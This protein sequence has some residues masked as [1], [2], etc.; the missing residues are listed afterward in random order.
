MTQPLEIIRVGVAVEKRVSKSPW[1]S[2]IWRPLWV[3]DGIPA[4]SPGTIIS[5]SDKITAFYAGEASI[6]LYRTETANYLSNLSSGSPL[7]WIILRYTEGGSAVELRGVTA[8][9]AEG[10]ALTGSGND[11]V[12]SVPMPKGIEV[13]INAFIA[14]HHEERPIHRRQRERAGRQS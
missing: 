3:F 8:D 12:E 6:E 13:K 5:S 10:E 11:L 1:A 4:A 2:E 14:R 7:L 9:P